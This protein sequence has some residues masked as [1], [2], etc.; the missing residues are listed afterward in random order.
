L[1]AEGQE[2]RAGAQ[3]TAAEGQEPG[4]GGARP[5]LN[6]EGRERRLRFPALSSRQASAQSAFAESVVNTAASRQRRCVR[7]FTPS[8]LPSLTRGSTRARALT[9]LPASLLPPRRPVHSKT[10]EEDMGD[11]IREHFRL[12]TR[13]LQIASDRSAIPSHGPTVEEGREEHLLRLVR[14]QMPK[15][16]EAT[17]GIVLGV[18]Q[19][20]Q[21]QESSADAPDTLEWRCE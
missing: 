19:L 17:K 1:G 11:I 14:E 10:V 21:R 7:Q 5:T 4:R 16:L 6:R 12:T 3:E 15:T 2:V 20:D 8:P 9:T 18:T 13:E